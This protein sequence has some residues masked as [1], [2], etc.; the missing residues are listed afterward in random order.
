M[1]FQKRLII[2]TVPTRNC[3]YYMNGVIFHASGSGKLYSCGSNVYGQIGQ[4]ATK[5][6]NKPVRTKQNTLYSYVIFIE[7]SRL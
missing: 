5:S 3:L 1:D 4:G 6:T 2:S 7:I